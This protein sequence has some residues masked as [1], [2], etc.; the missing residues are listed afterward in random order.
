MSAIM[1]SS[2]VTIY[3]NPACSTSK[4]ALALLRESGI[5]PTIIEYLK[6]P[7]SSAEIC[8]WLER[9]GASSVRS[10]LRSKAAPYTELD[11]ANP[12]WSDADLLSF[13]QQYPVLLERPIVIS[14]KGVRLCRPVQLVREIL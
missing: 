9:M 14:S 3:H 12:K 5:E 10:I 4:N 11:L 7:P 2:T 8:A 13:I 6:N 1:S